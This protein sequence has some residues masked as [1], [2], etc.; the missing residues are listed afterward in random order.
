MN[1]DKNFKDIRQALSEIDAARCEPGLSDQER[2]LLEK[3]AV[4]LRDAER[5]L[6]KKE[7]KELA[8]SLGS[9]EKD[10][11]ALSKEIRTRVT[12]MN[13]VSK[14][15]DKVGKVLTKVVGILTAIG[16]M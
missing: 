12:K 1:N 15:A 9:M 10:L 3:S 2:S 4:A 5:F 6:I 11:Q 13:K 7:Q 16:K 8:A 14:I